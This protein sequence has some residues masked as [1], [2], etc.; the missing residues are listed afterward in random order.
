MLTAA[1]KKDSQSSIFCDAPIGGVVVLSVAIKQPSEQQDHSL[2]QDQNFDYSSYISYMVRFE[3]RC[4][5]LNVHTFS[6]KV[7]R[8]QPKSGT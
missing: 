2:W 1:M 3:P 6:E 5:F 7:K 8:F 4:N